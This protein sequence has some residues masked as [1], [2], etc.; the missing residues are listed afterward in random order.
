MTHRQY[1]KRLKE[2]SDKLEAV[3]N[4]R[5]YDPHFYNLIVDELNTMHRAR[6]AEL[7]SS[8]I[9]RF[10]KWAGRRGFAAAAWLKKI[11]KK[12]VSL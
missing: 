7:N 2:L 4:T 8:S 11:F 12:A 5:P 3:A 9:L 6:Q 10:I 1:I